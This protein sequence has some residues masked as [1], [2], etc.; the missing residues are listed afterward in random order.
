[1]NETTS[2]LPVQ[3]QPK[4]SALAVW[5]LV[6]GV[7]SLMCFSILAAIPGVICGHKAISRIGK[8]GGGLSGKGL[9]IA[10]LVTGYIG[11]A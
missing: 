4:T 10:G 6:L 7:L 5:S 1:M 3:P 9:A 8:S 11:I 2:S